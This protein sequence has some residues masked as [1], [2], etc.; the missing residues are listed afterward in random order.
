MRA[1]HVRSIVFAALLLGGTIRARADEKEGKPADPPAPAAPSA[2]PVVGETPPPVT[3]SVWLN[4]AGGKSPLEGIEGKAV[5]VEFWGTWCGPCVRAMPHI[6]SLHERYAPRGLVVVGITRETADKVTDFLADNKYTM[7]IGCDPEQTCVK[8]YA[9]KGWPS[10]FIIAKNGTL[11]YAGDPYSAETA[12]EK[13][14][15][16]ESGPAALLTGWL[17]ASKGA[18]AKATRQALERLAEKATGAFD[19]KAW[20]LGVLG[21]EPPVP[22]APPKVDGAKALDA[23]VPAWKGTDPAK[24]TAALTPL[25]QAGPAA[26]DLKTWAR[27]ALGKAFPLAK[28]ELAAAFD[29]SRFEVALEMLLYR[30]PSAALLTQATKH[31]GFVSWCKSKR[32]DVRKDAR[33]GL[34]AIHWVFADPPMN[35]IDEETNKK[36]WADLSSSGWATSADEKHIVGLILGGEMVLQTHAQAWVN[37]HLAR[38]VFMNSVL[39]GKP[40]KGPAIAAEAKK[41]EAE[42]LADLKRTY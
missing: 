36:F 37:D 4:T 15:G 6:Q 16:L 39:D 1:G 33:K 38:F 34:M 28:E 3:A 18:D 22:A 8:A 30:N 32:D 5:L 27:A 40:L 20:A 21:S 23:V 10:T 12:V 13:A 17:D 35:G 7:P 19:V 31:T 41:E 29:G 26:F 11:L 42:I 2:G 9:L 25:A 14:L 24:R